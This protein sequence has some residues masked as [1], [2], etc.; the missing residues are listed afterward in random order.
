MSLPLRVVESSELITGRSV[1][2]FP[3]QSGET[4]QIATPLRSSPSSPTSPSIALILSTFPALGGKGNKGDTACRAAPLLRPPSPWAFQGQLL[5]SP[6]YEAH[7][8]VGARR[9]RVSATLHLSRTP[10]RGGVPSLVP[11]QAQRGGVQRTQSRGGAG[12][13]ALR[14][15]LPS[16]LGASPARC[17]S[18]CRPPART[19]CSPKT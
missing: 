11:A 18:P 15:T 9:T 3:S 16:R 5:L 19:A 14:P 17:A 7:S 13:L 10:A 2:I 1:V 12:V 4:R 6:V 8:P